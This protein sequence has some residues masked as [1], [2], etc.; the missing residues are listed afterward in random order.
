MLPAAVAMPMAQ[1]R[2]SGGTRRASAAMTMVNE[3]PARPSP[4]S[5]PPVSV[6]CNG[7]D[8]TAMSATPTA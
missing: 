4:T 6:I 7:V 1:E 3:P 5:T 8:A 2:R